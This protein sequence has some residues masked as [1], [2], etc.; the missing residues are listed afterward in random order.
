MDRRFTGSLSLVAAVAIAGLFLEPHL[1]LAQPLPQAEEKLPPVE[2]IDVWDFLRRLRHKE[3]APADSTSDET[4][5]VSTT[6]VPVLSSK[7]S[8]GLVVGGGASIEFPLGSM[9][10]TYVSSILAG[11][12]VSTKKQYSVSAR[13]ALFGAGN[14]WSLAGDHHYQVTGQE[15]FG[16]GT[17]A[18]SGD[19]VDIRYDSTKIVDTYYRG[20]THGM[21]VGIGFQFLRQSDVRPADEAA[22][23]WDQSPYVLYSNRYGFNLSGQV[24]AGLNLSVRRDTRDNVSDPDRGSFAESTFRAHFADFLG[25][26][27]TWQKLY[28]DLRAY[29]ALTKDTRHKVAFWTYGDFVTGG[30]APY[31]ALPATG[32]DPL[33]RSGRGYGEG[34][35]RGDRLVYGE[36]EYRVS[37]R[38]DGLVGMVGFVNATTVGS[39]FDDEP[40]FETVAIGGGFGFRLRLQKRSQTNLCLDFGW[41]RDGSRG[42]Y[43]ALAEAF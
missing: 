27:S 5:R 13:L 14:R 10:D 6:I 25:G 28:V 2:Q 29:R 8:T 40:L 43:L 31:L 38:R 26:D 41:G 7:P 32:T 11:A 23:D 33:G 3:P 4:R 19:R 17:D 16:F 1:A 36:V 20:V 37:L 18:S 21:F 24:S 39:T 30:I 22:T 35:F 9:Q 42:V 12:S 15:T 34:R